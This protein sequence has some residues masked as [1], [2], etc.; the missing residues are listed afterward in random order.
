MFQLLG[1]DRF[2]PTS[3]AL[4]VPFAIK[5]SNVQ[6]G[7]GNLLNSRFDEEAKAQAKPL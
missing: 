3:S 4:H 7:N 2:S 6:A 1:C 5:M